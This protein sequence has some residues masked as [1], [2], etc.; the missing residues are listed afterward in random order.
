MF[1]PCPFVSQCIFCSAPT[2][3]LRI[4]MRFCNLYT[5]EVG[6]CG[7]VGIV[8]HSISQPV[9]SVVVG[10]TSGGRKGHCN[11]AMESFQLYPTLSTHYPVLLPSDGS[12]VVSGTLLSGAHGDA[13][14]LISLRHATHTDH[15]WHHAIVACQPNMPPS[16]DP[17]AQ[18]PPQDPPH[19]RHKEE[20][21]NEPDEPN[22]NSSSNVRR[23][24]ITPDVLRSVFHMPINDA[25]KALGIGVTVRV[26]GLAPES[27]LV[28]QIHP[29]TLPTPPTRQKGA[30]KVL[31]QV[32][33]QALALSQAQE[34][35]QADCQCGAYDRC[36]SSVWVYLEQSVC[37]C[38]YAHVCVLC[39]SPPRDPPR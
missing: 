1:P 10:S 28:A 37:P 7:V 5:V 30:E 25:A 2:H 15:L 21:T 29:S 8:Q 12:D 19:H 23:N 36:E 20:D 4:S 24:D 32:W 31:P 34:H 16:S 38:L 13:C 27:Y 26:A 35:G 33:C 39:T 11:T 3:V 6:G 17:P 14:A 18:P 22:N 9:C